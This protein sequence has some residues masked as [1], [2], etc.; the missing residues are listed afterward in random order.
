MDA[1]HSLTKYI[2]PK[3]IKDIIVVDASTGEE[4]CEGILYSL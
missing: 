1:I 2:R 3:R 4:L